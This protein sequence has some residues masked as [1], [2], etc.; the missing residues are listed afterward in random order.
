MIKAPKND[1][2]GNVEVFDNGSMKITGNQ[3]N[4]SIDELKNLIEDKLKYSPNKENYL[5]MA[6]NL[7]NSQDE[8][9]LKKALQKFKEFGKELGK[10]VF[11]SG[12][13]PLVIR[14]AKNL[15]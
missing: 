8:D 9:V 3:V 11:I 4:I 7:K 12:L 10:G 1:P 6:D 13:S 15:F 2:R 14:L 5:E